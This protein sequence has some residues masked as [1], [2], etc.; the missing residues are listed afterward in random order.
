MRSLDSLGLSRYPFS[1]VPPPGPTDQWADRKSVRDQLQRL[2][3]SWGLREGA[4]MALLWADFGAGKTHALRYLEALCIGQS[5]PFLPIYCDL[6]ESAATFKDVYDQLIVRVPEDALCASIVGFRSRHGGAWLSAPSCRGDRD[7]LQVLWVLSQAGNS[8]FG[9][10]ARSWL[11]G[12]RL[13]ARNLTQLEVPSSIRTPEDAIRSLVTVC[14][15]LA[16]GGDFRRV[17]LLMDEFQRIGTVSRRR[18]GDINAGLNTAFNSCPR[19]SIVLSYSFGV[20]EH[21][22]IMVSP[23]VRSRVSKELQLPFLTEDEAVEFVKDTLASAA[24]PGGRVLFDAD[25]VRA[26]VQMV[27]ALS[28]DRITPRRLMKACG[29][30]LEGVLL[31]EEI[32]LPVAP[33]VARRLCVLDD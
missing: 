19:L 10:L 26:V 27:S 24:A 33:T 32:D 4:A 18:I 21:I 11:R 22:R 23:E 3:A 30:I 1:I 5:P 31:D 8:A 6:P 9:S 7:T 2:V 29:A 20:P 12:E 14:N 28:P 25:T 17:V 16:E 15:V 13:G